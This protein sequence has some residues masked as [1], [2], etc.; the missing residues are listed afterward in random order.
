MG[1]ASDYASA[2]LRR[3]R[4]PMEPIGFQPDWADRPRSGKYYPGV[5]RFPLPA[6]GDGLLPL[7]GAMLRD[8][9]GV[10]GR[11]TAVH[12]NSNTELLP[13]Y[14]T[15][16]WAR[17]VASGGGLYPATIYWACGASGP[18]APGLYYYNG[19]QH[20]MERLLAGDV[21]G[22]IAA[23]CP[24][25]GDTGQFLIVGAKFWQ[26]SYKYNSFAYH[27]ITM[28]I[29]TITS[30]WQ[31]WGLA[32]GLRVAVHLWFDERALGEL[33]GVDPA[34]EGIFALVALPSARAT[35]PATGLAT[36]LAAGLAVRRADRERSRTV[37]RFDT[38]RQVHRATL[39]DAASP[40]PA[41]AVRGAAPRPVP[42][43][44]DRIALPPPAPVTA[45]LRGSLRARHSCFGRFAAEPALEPERLAALLAAATHPLTRL[46]VFVNHVRSIPPGSYLYDQED[47]DLRLVTAGPQGSFLQRN[48]FLDNYNVE[49]AAVVM[50]P[51]LRVP[52]L[53]DA[54]GDRGL[55]LSGATIGGIAQAVY[56]ASAG[57]GLGCGVALGFDGVSYCEALGLDADDEY[58]M[59]IMMAG[60][61]HDPASYQFDL[62]GAR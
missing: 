5:E 16:T 27:A 21:T 3:A 14:A 40:P 41:D 48:Y 54:V 60:H 4:V 37:I 38:V 62:T 15:A 17:G 19:T 42:V 24:D 25:A 6:G 20:A 51:T 2:V 29:G 31:S 11:R 45:G 28:D 33:L 47:R 49:Q 57:L 9:F 55:R 7:L 46:F 23:A 12:V 8:T 61:E 53:L 43:A 26:N 39:T 35:G 52:A 32:H 59:L 18:L 1:V 13:E 22:Q 50:V 56:L 58:P 44:G 34:D 30:A 36:G 10:H